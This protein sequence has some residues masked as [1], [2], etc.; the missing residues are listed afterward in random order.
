[1]CP[2]VRARVLVR[3]DLGDPAQAAARADQLAAGIAGTGGCAVDLVAWVDAP[4]DATRLDL[5]SEALLE[6]LVTRLDQLGVEV[7]ASLST[8]GRVWWSHDCPDLLCRGGSRRLDAAVLMRMRAEYVYAGY[9]PLATRDELAADLARDEERSGRVAADERLGSSRVPAN[10]ERWRETQIGFLAGLLVPG[11]AR[12]VS[13]AAAAGSSGARDGPPLPGPDVVR[14]LRALADVRVR[15]VVLRRLIV[16]DQ[17]P[18]GGLRGTRSPCWRTWSDV[19]RPEPVR[20][21][22]PCSASSRGCAG[23]GPWRRSRWTGP[24]PTIPATGWAC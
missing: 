19:A 14:A 4:D 15:D 17:S 3:L 13:G 24:R 7:P 10:L 1:M 23:M 21:P 8:N 9:A 5:P 6:E 11:P 2:T 12:R 22:R 16:A 18:E 20:R